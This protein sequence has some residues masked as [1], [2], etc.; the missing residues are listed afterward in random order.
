VNWTGDIVEIADPNAAST[1]I[2]MKGD[3]TITANFA[4]DTHTLTVTAGMGGTITAPATSP[5]TYDYGTVVTITAVPNTGYHFVNWTG[6]IVEIA[7][8]NAASTTIEMKGDYIITANFA[9]DTHTLTVTA[10]MGGTITAPA[11]SPSTYNYGMVV[12]ITAV[13]N[14]GYHFVEWMGD[15]S[16]VANATAAS[17]TIIMNGDYAITATFALDEHTLTVT[18]GT[19]GTITA[20][21]TSPSTYNYG[22]GV[23]ITAVPNTG[24]HFVEWT[25]DIVEI[26]DP[27]AASTTIEM[28]GDYT[29]TAN[30][31][32]NIHSLTLMVNP[33]NSGTVN[34]SPTGPLY[35]YGTVVTL[36]P[37]P[38]EGY[39]F[40]YWSGTDIPINN[41]DGTWSITMDG[42]KNLTA[43]FAL[44]SHCLK[45]NPVKLDNSMA[46]GSLQTIELGLQNTCSEEVS[47]SLNER[48]SLLHEGFE[49]GDISPTGW[50]TKVGVDDG[51]DKFEWEIKDIKYSNPLDV[52]DGGYSA[53]AEWSETN[54]KNE[55]LLTPAFSAKDVSNLGLSFRASSTTWYP[56]ATVRVWVTDKNGVEI[57]EF[58]TEPL[59]DM[60]RDEIWGSMAYRSVFVDLGDFAGYDEN[61]RVA[62]QYIGVNGQNFGLDLIDIGHY[63]AG[64]VPWISSIT[65]MT[66][67]VESGETKNIT[68]TFNSEGLE[69][70]ENYYADIDFNYSPYPVIPV[71]IVLRTGFDYY[72]PLILK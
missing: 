16:T 72:L 35:E 1:T 45:V 40:H 34:L 68:I 12:T 71:P 25:G 11:T 36:T 21:L 7:D 27:T 56:G 64:G 8:P 65:P 5:S 2:E 63:A 17:T 28:K 14:T 33:E 24:Y 39:T 4:I 23:A 46:P 48:K 66:G 9:I 51:N 61:I 55:W 26:A 22:T 30:F 67:S 41:N 37:M 58:S 13:P 59:W 32:L 50:M 69:G 60:H 54:Y 52:D 3:Y 31:A 44:D 70:G 62:W 57:K 49:N 47:Y 19:G 29:I 42:D 53:W 18:A 20:P 38:T 43:N 6:D 15:V 10:G